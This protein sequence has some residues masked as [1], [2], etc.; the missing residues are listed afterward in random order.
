MAEL[1]PGNER[2]KYAYAEHLRYGE[3]KSEPTVRGIE[4]ALHRWETHTGLAD[5]ATFNKAQ[6]MAFRAAL[7]K[8]PAGEKRLGAATILS[9]VK[10]LQRFFGW[11]MLQPGMRRRIKPTDI[12]YLSLSEK[13]ARAAS[14]SPSKPF[15]TLEQLKHVL[16]TMP[17]ETEIERRDRAVFAL[18]ML[19]GAR[20]DAAASLRIGNVD[21][22]R[23]LIVQDPATVRTKASKLIETCILPL[24]EE[25]E[26]AFTDW[27]RYLRA[28]LLYGPDDPVFP[29]TQTRI[30]PQRGPVADGLKRAVWCNAAPIRAIFKR[31]FAAA[32]LPYFSPHRV[33][34]TLVEY[35]YKQ[36]RS[37]EELKAFSQNLGHAN[38]ATTLM[39]YG[40]IPLTRQMELIR[41]AGKG[42]DRDEELRL[43]MREIS[44]KLG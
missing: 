14:A 17:A 27:V 7:A 21:L 3:G 5:F 29:Q 9:T 30:D 15:P 11:L 13:D 19:T 10:A 43:L 2:I 40:Q 1:N 42:E 44:R 41:N 18:I 22:D 33:R 37:P 8:P 28:D 32:G 24:G 31:A 6:A 12:A 23:G 39:S 35:A 38:V 26:R 16:A 34:N 36:C 25:V 4:K 20:D